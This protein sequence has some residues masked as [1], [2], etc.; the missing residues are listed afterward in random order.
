[1][2]VTIP[3][4][5]PEGFEVGFEVGGTYRR[6]RRGQ[7]RREDGQDQSHEQSRL[8]DSAV[9]PKT[10]T[11]QQHLGRRYTTVTSASYVRTI[12]LVAMLPRV[13]TVGVLVVAPTASRGRD[14]RG[15]A[16]FCTLHRPGDSQ[17]DRPR[18]ADRSAS[19]ACSVQRERGSRSGASRPADRRRD[20]ATTGVQRLDV[21]L[22]FAFS[23][24]P[25][26]PSAS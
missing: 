3:L 18:D 25:G 7:L 8:V 14:P 19:N 11:H 21:T 13:I 16:V 20:P 26:G 15:I 24:T 5:Q 12:T 9:P 23:L 4:S 22:D 10:P 17:H 1:M 6:T 2:Q